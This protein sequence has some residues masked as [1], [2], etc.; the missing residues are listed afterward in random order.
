MPRGL[1][2]F[3]TTIEGDRVTI[4]LRT[5]ILGACSRGVWTGCSEPEQQRTTRSR[6]PVA[7]Y[8]LR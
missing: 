5:L 4:D 7:Q 1:D 6:F 2:R 8:K 3:P